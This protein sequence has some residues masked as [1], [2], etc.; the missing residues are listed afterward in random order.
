[1]NIFYKS[2]FNELTIFQHFSYSWFLIIIVVLIF[3][4]IILFRFFSFFFEMTGAL[5]NRFCLFITKKFKPKTIQNSKN[6]IIDNIL[7]Y[8]IEK[9]RK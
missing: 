5:I 4:F 3:S 6:V 1:M 2:L 9:K 8:L 7:L